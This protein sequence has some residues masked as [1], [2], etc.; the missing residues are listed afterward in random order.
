M[1][2]QNNRAT[3]YPVFEVVKQV[4]TRTVS[5]FP[6]ALSWLYSSIMERTVPFVLEPWRDGEVLKFDV[7]DAAETRN[8]LIERYNEFVVGIPMP[9]SNETTMRG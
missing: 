8:G 1:H 5:R 6:A 2:E 7:N 4:E 3:S 9:V